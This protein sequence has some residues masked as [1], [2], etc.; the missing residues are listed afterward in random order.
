MSEFEY[1][2]GEIEEATSAVP[3]RKVTAS[4]VGGATATV[5]VILLNWIVG[6]DAP[7]GLEGALAVLFGF[8]AGYLT[9]EA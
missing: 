6:T 3:T 2:D 9:R 1:H 8:V 5:V 4:A 7:A